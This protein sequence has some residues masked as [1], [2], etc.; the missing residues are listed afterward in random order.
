MLPK[1]CIGS[2]KRNFKNA[3]FP[4]SEGGGTPPCPNKSWNVALPRK[5]YAPNCINWVLKIAFSAFSDTPFFSSMARFIIVLA[6]AS[7]QERW[8][9]Y[10]HENSQYFIGNEKWIFS[11]MLVKGMHQIVQ[12]EFENCIFFSFWGGNS[13]PQKL[14]FFNGQRFIIVL[15]KT[16]IQERWEEWTW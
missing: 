14:H 9:D 3:F 1:G 15:A 6:K 2:C 5:R 7:K 16:S 12:I 4:A 10:R 13:P 11:K 8:E